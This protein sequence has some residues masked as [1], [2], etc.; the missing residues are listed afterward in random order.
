[1]LARRARGLHIDCVQLLVSSAMKGLSIACID[2]G[3]TTGLWWGCFGIRELR[4]GPWAALQSA[5]KDKRMLF[6]QQSTDGRGDLATAMEIDA[7]LE[8][9]D[10]LTRRVSDNKLEGVHVVVIEDF[11]LQTQ[12]MKRDLLS[13]VRLT[14]MIEAYIYQR[15]F[16][17]QYLPIEVKKQMPSSAK[18]VITNDRM[19]RN[20]FVWSHNRRHE[21]DAFRHGALY[22][23]GFCNSLTQGK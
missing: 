16:Q 2:P 21:W 14:A 3:E 17:R 8:M 18:T 23:R 12:T 20:G 9:L 13:P 5:R 1:M 15:S 11:I 7:W 6:D 4:Q 19:K 22:L 10:G